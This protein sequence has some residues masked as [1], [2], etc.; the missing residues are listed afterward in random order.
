MLVFDTEKYGY[1]IF[2]KVELFDF[3]EIK[4]SKSALFIQDR[5]KVRFRVET[6]FFWIEDRMVAGTGL[7]KTWL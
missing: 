6:E 3:L 4:S 5:S 1:K 7:V 2:P